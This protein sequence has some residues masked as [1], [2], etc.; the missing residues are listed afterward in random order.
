MGN[1]SFREPS[2]DLNAK[3]FNPAKLKQK[4]VYF[5]FF[6]A[7]KRFSKEV[8]SRINVFPFYLTSALY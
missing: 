6:S 7:A 3:S 4:E 1:C 5:N 2:V 8:Y